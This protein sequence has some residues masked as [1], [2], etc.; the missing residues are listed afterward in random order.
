[1]LDNEVMLSED[2]NCAASVRPRSSVMFGSAVD[3]FMLGYT[4]YYL[5][6]TGDDPFL[7][8]PDARCDTI[9][10]SNDALINVKYGMDACVRTVESVELRELLRQMLS[11]EPYERPRV[12]HILNTDGQLFAHSYLSDMMG[13]DGIVASYAKKLEE[14]IDNRGERLRNL[15]LLCD[16]YDESLLKSWRSKIDKRVGD[17][18]VTKAEF[19]H[20][21][22]VTTTRFPLLT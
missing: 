17:R 2:T 13:R 20:V 11:H 12:A 14:G 5:A 21:S 19:P 7:A 10:K 15:E 8:S 22:R 6:T 9:S 1:M 3:V 4:L 16:S 18:I